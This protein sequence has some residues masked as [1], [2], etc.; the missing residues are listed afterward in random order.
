VLALLVP[1]S[2][3]V[4]VVRT[5]LSFL[6]FLAQLALAEKEC[7]DGSDEPE[8]VCPN[9]CEE[10]GKEHRQRMEAEM[11]LRRTVCRWSISQKCH[12]NLP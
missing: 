5:S 7:C 12:I 9:I 8:G 3:T 11:K 4:Y 1:V 10:M 6:S 2:T